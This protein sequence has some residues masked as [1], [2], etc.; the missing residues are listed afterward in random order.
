MRIGTDHVCMNKSRTVP[1][2]AILRGALKCSRTRHRIGA[3]D[4]FKM[5]IWEARD[6][7]RN[8]A[9]GRLHF[10]RHGDRVAVVLHGKNHGQLVEGGGVHRLPELALAGGA[11]SERD[12]GNL[13]AVE[14]HV[15]ELAII[16]ETGCP[17]SRI[18]C[19]KWGL[20]G[21]SLFHVLCGGRDFGRPRVLR[22][23]P[24]SLGASHRLK[25]LRSRGGGLSDNVE[26]LVAPVRRHLPPAG[27][28]VIGRADR[29]QKHL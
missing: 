25:N 26:P 13:V 7:P 27:T 11:V 2:A 3:V 21:C 8:A 19:E 10:H 12:V 5:E 18:F 1:L 15:F 20:R 28:G 23:I 16:Y 4:F 24:S 14:G 29:L 9:S 22:K 6:Q 17:I